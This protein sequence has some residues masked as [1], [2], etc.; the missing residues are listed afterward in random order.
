MREIKK[1][2]DVLDE[3]GLY[4][5][6]KTIVGPSMPEM[7]I[8]GKRV[9]SF[10][11]NNYLGLAASEKLISAAIKTAK[12]YGVGSS[13][14]RLLSGNL[15]IF[16]DLEKEIAKFKKTEDAIIF[17][18]GYM[19]NVGAI[20]AVVGL[21][22]VSP[23]SFFKRRTV[24]FSDQLNHASIIDGCK[25]SGGKIIIYKHCDMKDLE[26]KLKSYKNRRKLIVTDGVF[27]MDGDMAPL[28]EIVKLA[29]KYNS[30]TMVDDAHATGILGKTGSGTAEHFGVDHEIDIK[31]GTLSKALGVSGAY[32]AGSRELLKYLRVGAR[33]YMFATAM[34]PMVAGAVMAALKEVRENLGLRERLWE[35]TKRLKDGFEK[36]GFYTFNSQSPIIP[37]LIGE[38]EKAIQV[39]KILFE[40]GFYAPCVRWP[41]VGKGEARIRFTVMSLHTESQIGNLLKVFGETTKALKITK[42]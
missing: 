27:S 34:S 26:R 41:A 11:S 10:S 40:K 1:V 4:P 35:N 23:S 29:K 6:I 38:E 13:G 2:L 22:K 37:V 39:S 7:I 14:S 18:A 20:S 30:L 42:G 25:L 3:H 9:L 8:D 19:A 31:M 16:V 17:T 5:E 32:V 21:L 28:P 15:K 24:I 12:E 33:A 36:M